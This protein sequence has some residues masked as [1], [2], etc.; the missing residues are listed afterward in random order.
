MVIS[1]MNMQVLVISG[2]HRVQDQSIV[3]MVMY[4]LYITLNLN[5]KLN[6]SVEVQG[7]LLHVIRLSQV[8]GKIL[9]LSMKV[10][11]VQLLGPNKKVVLS[12]KMMYIWQ[13]PMVN[14]IEI[15]LFKEVVITRIVHVT[16]MHALNVIRLDTFQEIALIKVIE[17]VLQEIKAALIVA[18][19]VTFLLIVLNLKRNVV[20]IEGKVVVI[21]SALDAMKWVTC[22]EIALTK[23]MIVV[24]SNGNV[25]TM[26]TH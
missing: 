12:S 8:A 16:Q 15:F 13:N 18:K 3:T 6:H 25:V 10:E 23:V 7:T 11:E 17:V 1:L 24:A 20:V 2:K 22:R 14:Q 21:L 9:G 5:S 19:M 4:N 26:V